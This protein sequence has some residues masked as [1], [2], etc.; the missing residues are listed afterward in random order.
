MEYDL[1]NI[2][3]YQELKSHK[4]RRTVPAPNSYFFNL[5]CNNCKE[6]KKCFSH[7]QSKVECIKCNRA[8]A[9]PTGGKLKINIEFA[10]AEN[11]NNANRKIIKKDHKEF[12]KK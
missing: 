5:K 10:T 12:D 9:L 1:L 4:L 3:Y 8:L 2:P 11:I 7:G 6:V